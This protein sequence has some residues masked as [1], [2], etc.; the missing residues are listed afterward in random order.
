MWPGPTSARHTGGCSALRDCRGRD[1]QGRRRDDA[2]ETPS[3]AN[4]RELLYGAYVSPG[5]QGDAGSWPLCDLAR[6]IKKHGLPKGRWINADEAF[7][8]SESCITPYPG[9]LGSDHRA[10][11]PVTLASSPSHPHRQQ[12]A[13]TRSQ[14][15]RTSTT[16]NPDYACPLS[17]ALAAI[18]GSGA[19]AA[20]PRAALHFPH[21]LPSLTAD[22][23]VETLG[24]FWR[25]SRMG[26]DRFPHLVSACFKLSNFMLRYKEAER[27]Q[28]RCDEEPFRADDGSER[29]FD[30]VRAMLKRNYVADPV[31]TGLPRA[32]PRRRNG[33]WTLPSGQARWHRAHGLP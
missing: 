6:W 13:C 10:C 33:R 31:A 30:D 32:A 15:R 27:E 8:G 7:K 12:G 16:S 3:S 25:P 21:G 17:S 22:S 2:A 18:T 24:V 4:G 20:A 14:A 5:G 11:R 1:G 9:S 26:I 19:R 23:V 29:S 28:D